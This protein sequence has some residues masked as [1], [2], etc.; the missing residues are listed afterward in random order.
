MLLPRAKMDDEMM[1]VVPARHSQ[2]ENSNPNNLGFDLD[3][4]TVPHNLTYGG[5]QH[6]ITDH[7]FFTS[8]S[9]SSHYLGNSLTLT[10]FYW[11]G[12]QALFSPFP[13]W[14]TGVGC[15]DVVAIDLFD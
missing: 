10:H 7:R 12:V 13:S 2:P 6:H 3:I 8:S 1:M 9:S 4:A 5:Q 15:L 11:Q 14:P